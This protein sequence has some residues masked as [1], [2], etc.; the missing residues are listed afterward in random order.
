MPFSKSEAPRLILPSVDPFLKTNKPINIPQSLNSPAH[1][2]LPIKADKQIEY[3][4]QIE[5]VSEAAHVPPTLWWW[6]W[7]DLLWERNTACDRL[8]NYLSFPCAYPSM[9]FA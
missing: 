3:F 4:K 2:N 8:N 9:S 1:E 6:D 5:I 7:H